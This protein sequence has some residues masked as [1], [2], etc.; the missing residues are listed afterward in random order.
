[1]PRVVAGVILLS[2]IGCEP[3][4]HPNTDVCL[5][6]SKVIVGTSV[7]ETLDVDRCEIDQEYFLELRSAA[8]AALAPT[9]MVEQ[10]ASFELV[11]NYFSD[12]DRVPAVRVTQPPHDI[13][14]TF[15]YDG[16]GRYTVSGE[17]A[18]TVDEGVWQILY[19]TAP[20]AKQFWLLGTDRIP[21]YLKDG[22]E[23]CRWINTCSGE[24]DVLIV[25]DA[26]GMKQAT[27]THLR[28]YDADIEGARRS[29][30]SRYSFACEPTAKAGAGERR[31]NLRRRCQE[32]PNRR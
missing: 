21:P 23:H 9:V 2:V 25:E 3:V 13:F 29:I 7:G 6:L 18:S 31:K 27:V 20:G 8:S 12:L 5:K 14:P 1:M 4:D 30:E 15:E 32:R 26:Y 28:L 24:V 17:L 11:N 10:A 19:L 16:P 22:L